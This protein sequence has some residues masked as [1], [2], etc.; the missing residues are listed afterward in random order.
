MV[1]KDKLVKEFFSNMSYGNA[2]DPGQKDQGQPLFTL[3]NR[4]SIG[5]VKVFHYRAYSY[6]TIPNYAT[7]TK[8][9]E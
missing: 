2:S 6:I 1:T 5:K 7:K 8:E 9:S 3:Y 4:S